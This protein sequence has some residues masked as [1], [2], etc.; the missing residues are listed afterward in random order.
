MTPAEWN[1]ALAPEIHW[2]Q[3]YETLAAE[4]RA[5]LAGCGDKTLATTDLVKALYPPKYADGNDAATTVRK[6]MFK[7]LMTMARHDMSDCATRGAQKIIMGRPSRPWIWHK[8]NGR[9]QTMGALAGALLAAA[10]LLLDGA[11]DD[12]AWARLEKAA[13]A[14]RAYIEREK[15]A[16]AYEAYMAAAP[17]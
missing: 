16:G 11:D 9:P 12:A 13:D 3:A 1:A 2:Q 8:S 7:G 5:Y 17:G 6:R 14:L 15:P 4:A 10:E